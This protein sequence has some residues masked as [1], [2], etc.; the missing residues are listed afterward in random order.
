MKRSKSMTESRRTITALAVL[1]IVATAL[2]SGGAIDAAEGGSW[3][4]FSKPRRI[5]GGDTHHFFGYYGITPWD[6]SGRY[7]L[8]IRTDSHNRLPEAEDTALIGTIDMAGGEFEGLAKTHAWNLQQG[9]MQQW[10]PGAPGPSIIYNDRRG[11]K[12]VSV[13][14]NTETGAERILPRA[15]SALSADGTKALSINYA[16]LRAMRPTTGYAGIED[17]AADSDRPAGD[18][19]YIL[20]IESGGAKL[21]YSI[22]AI[23]ESY[24]AGTEDDL[25]G[26]KFWIAH[27]SFNPSARR[28]SFLLRYSAG[29][30]A[31]RTAAM[32]ASTDGHELETLVEFGRSVSHFAWRTDTELLLTMDLH[33]RGPGS[34][35]VLFDLKTGEHREIGGDVL[36][37]DGHPAFSPD[38]RYFVTDTYPDHRMKQSLYLYDMESGRSE[39]LAEFKHS[40]AFVGPTRCDL[41]PRWSR[42]G[43]YISVDSIHPGSRQIYIIKLDFHE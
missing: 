40:P 39:L 1:L 20:D 22:D 6:P 26:R 11:D 36:L 17:P 13:I 34:S 27:T 35:H 12:A 29:F 30:G 23:V 43:R 2:L 38:G 4:E 14:L 18:G 28:F 37:R 21:L 19:I 41:H 42:D 31:F 8:A 10:L 15:I 5:T 32:L 9:A 3:A 25:R 24:T 33:G 7:M 16:R